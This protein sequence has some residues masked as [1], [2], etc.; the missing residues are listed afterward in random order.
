VTHDGPAARI[1][2]SWYY[3]R[4]GNP[5]TAV[6]PPAWQK[7]IVDIRAEWAYVTSF[8]PES[9]VAGFGKKPVGELPA[10]LAEMQAN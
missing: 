1:R 10:F 7:F 9:E 8:D 6:Y 3:D 4:D 5:T 2:N